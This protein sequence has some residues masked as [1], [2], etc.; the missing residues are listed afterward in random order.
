MI[1]LIVLSGIL[2]LLGAGV[3]LIIQLDEPSVILH[4]VVLWPVTA[5]KY[6]RARSTWK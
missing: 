2:Y 3:S 6:I 1:T 5:F 4:D